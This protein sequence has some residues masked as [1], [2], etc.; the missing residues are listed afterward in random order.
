MRRI[1]VALLCSLLIGSGLAR[2]YATSDEG[3]R[4]AD[5][6]VDEYYFERSAVESTLQTAAYQ[7]RIID[8]I[9]RPAER[10]PWKQYRDIFLT[11]KR[12]REGVQFLN[13]N[14][15]DLE[16]AYKEYR[17]PPHIITAIIGVETSYGNNKG[18]FRVIDAL[19][20]LGFD[21]PKR[22][23][24]FREQLKTFFVLACEERIIPFD[25][26]SSC[27]RDSQ[28]K[29]SGDGRIIHELVGSYAG[30]MGYGQFI[31]SSYRSFA[32]DYDG[33]GLR[34]IWNN[35]TDAIGS[36]ANYF[37]EHDWRDE[38]LVI[39]FVEIDPLSES[40]A[41]LANDT[42]QPTRS[43]LQWRELGVSSNAQDDVDAALFS[44]ETEDDIEYMLGFH[45]FYVI[46]RY[47]HSRLYARAVYELAESIRSRL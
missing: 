40:L 46:T 31:P 28:A 37:A 16:R 41:T 38:A 39:E 26:D 32:V 1:G 43:V 20:T 18:T 14:S 44:Y 36:V 34:D 47:N 3:I 4:L 19:T 30:A 22:A 24:F 12:I 10:K 21:Y 42:L 6:L 17:V 8:L 7:Q 45:D 29:A 15:E 27:R 25:K 5:E 35:K 33:D 23:T 13:A 11:E 2:D 9:T